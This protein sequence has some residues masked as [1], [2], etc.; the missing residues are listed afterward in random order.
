MAASSEY[1]TRLLIEVTIRL[2]NTSKGIC[3]AKGIGY[4]GSGSNLKAKGR[5]SVVKKKANSLQIQL[6]RLIY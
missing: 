4:N 2:Y 6:I 5:D 1:A 3:V